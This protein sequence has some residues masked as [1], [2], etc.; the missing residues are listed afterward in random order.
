M[1][2][3]RGRVTVPVF[4]SNVAATV[5]PTPGQV[6]E[7]LEAE[8]EKAVERIAGII[9]D[10]LIRQARVNPEVREFVIKGEPVQL[11][12]ELCDG[13]L[14]DEWKEAICRVV[15]LRGWL[16]EWTENGLILRKPLGVG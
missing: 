9:R 10:D 8:R 2:T 1:D 15:H 7:A 4:V 6:G 13:G 5:L 16:T 12:A 11:I 14:T 3:D